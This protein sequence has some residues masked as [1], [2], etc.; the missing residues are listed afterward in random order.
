[1]K[2]EIEI[3]FF[4][5]GSFMERKFAWVD[6]KKAIDLFEKTVLK[7]RD[8]NTHVMVSHRVMDTNENYTLVNVYQNDPKGS[9]PGKGKAR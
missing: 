4:N 5:N 3:I 9:N 2:H 7:Y 1:M 6:P 8:S